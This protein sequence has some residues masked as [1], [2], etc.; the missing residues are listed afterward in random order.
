MKK[1]SAS[2]SHL[3]SLFFSLHSQSRRN[4]HAGAISRGQ[5]GGRRDHARGWQHG[6]DHHCGSGPERAGGNLGV[7]QQHERAGVKEA[8]VAALIG[9]GPWWAWVTGVAMAT[10][11]HRGCCWIRVR[12][13]VAPPSLP[14]AEAAG[15]AHQRHPSPQSTAAALDGGGAGSFQSMVANTI[16]VGSS[17]GSY[18][19]HVS[20]RGSRPRRLH[21]GLAQHPEKE[22]CRALHGQDLRADDYQPASSAK[23]DSECRRWMA[24]PITHELVH[25]EGPWGR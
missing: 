13:S 15:S 4:G 5:G 3:S 7:A 19:L 10:S 12:V 22:P 18:S 17:W 11:R 8:V 9:V 1:K 2:T 24:E 23:E 16:L 14:R 20:I 21:A 6:H 25:G